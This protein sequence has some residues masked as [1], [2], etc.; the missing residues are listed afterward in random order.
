MMFGFGDDW[1]PL[2]ETT[3][4]MEDFVVEYVHSMVRFRNFRLKNINRLIRLLNCIEL[5]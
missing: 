1:E 3:A 4:L 2:E 5:L